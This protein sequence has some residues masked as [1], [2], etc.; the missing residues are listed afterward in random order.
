MR[1]SRVVFVLALLLLPMLAAPQ[2]QD[3]RRTGEDDVLLI[4]AFSGGGTRAAAFG[5]GVSQA[6]RETAGRTSKTR[7]KKAGTPA[8]PAPASKE[9]GLRITDFDRV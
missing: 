6:M 2:E 1:E 5:Y 9:T 3:A 7:K 4:V 8:A